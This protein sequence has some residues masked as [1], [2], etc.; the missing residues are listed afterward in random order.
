MTGFY[1]VGLESTRVTNIEKK[2]LSHPYVGALLLF[3]RNFE[4]PEQLQILLT[5]VRTIRPDIF[6][7]IDHEGGIV[8][9]LQRH[10][11]RALPAARVYGD[12]YDLDAKVG[13][14]LS[15]KYGELMARDLLAHDIDLSLAPVID[16]HGESNVI[17]QLDRAFHA[18]PDVVELLAEAFIDGMNQAGMPS[19]AKHFPGHGTTLIDSHVGHPVCDK[20]DIELKASDLKPFNG[21]IQKNKLDGIMPAHITYSQIDNDFIASFSSTWLKDIARSQMHFQGIILSDCLSMKGADFG[22]LKTRSEMALQAG[23]DML[24][25]CN[26]PP[27]LILDTCNQ[28]KYTQSPDSLKRLE[29]F[30]M[31]MRRFK[32][33]PVH[34]SQSV[35][36]SINSADSQDKKQQD[37]ESMPDTSTDGLNR[38]KQV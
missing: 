4:S 2:M 34:S 11:F 31:K 30:K 25:L 3:S 16:L 7:A 29:A 22:D 8:Q 24:I 23:C 21:L 9:R 17:G 33:A 28:I 12:A 14:K 19:V 20:T 10:G 26:Q 36:Q 37:K 32:N 38:T 13:L 6:V 5:D 18:N 15:R 35:F 1:M 27:E